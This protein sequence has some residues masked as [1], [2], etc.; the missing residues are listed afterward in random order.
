MNDVKVVITK[1]MAVG[2]DGFGTPLLLAVNQQAE[3]PF[4]LCPDLESVKALS[5]ENTDL[6]KAAELIFMQNEAPDKIG[7]CVSTKSAL[8]ALGEVF[9]EDWRQ[10]VLFGLTEQ[11]K[12]KDIAAFVE[13]K[14]NKL[15][16]MDVTTKDTLSDFQSFERTVAFYYPE[17]NELPSP[18]CAL[19]GA[20]AGKKLGSLTY[21]NQ[22]LKGITPLKLEDSE[23]IALHEAG[24]ITVLK[25]AGDIV[26]SEG[27]TTSKEYIDIVDLRDYIIQEI[28]YRTQKLLNNVDKVPYDNTGI[29]MLESVVTSVLQEAY[30]NR[31]I[32]VDEDGRPDYS[33]PFAKRSETSGMDRAKRQYLGGKFQ[34]GLAGAVHT[35][36][37]RGEIIV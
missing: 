29:A 5:G 34:F 27:L 37:I 25:K 2:T 12:P 30:N 20:T 4:T 32:A 21:K 11:D 18:V 22:K 16:F 6:Y 17:Q 36:E 31:I 19:L 23:I 8:E 33:V 3:K 7:V 1:N 9:D 35:V 13:A 10:L 14:K 24:A 26:S 15:Y 28:E